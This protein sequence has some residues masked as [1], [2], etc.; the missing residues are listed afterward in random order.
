M[1]EDQQRQSV[2]DE[3]L[4]WQNTPHH[5][6]AHIKG[7]GV[8]CGWLPIMVYSAVGLMPK[9]EPGRYPPDFMMHRGEE[10][11]KS[12]ADKYG[13][14]LPAG[15]LPKKGDFALYKFGRI[16][17]HGAIVM[18]WPRIIHSYVGQG[19]VQALGNQGQLEG[20]D[21]IFYTLWGE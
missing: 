9:V 3:A 5:N 4:T 15:Q 21:V 1:T 14:R 6:G 8:D 20:R 18:D 10:W 12:I 2:I 16:Y 7:A 17:S 13:R 19:V 11:Y